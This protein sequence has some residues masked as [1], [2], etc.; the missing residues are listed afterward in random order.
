MKARLV[1]QVAYGA[2][3]DAFR[4][5]RPL[6]VARTLLTLAAGRN[7]NEARYIGLLDIT[8]E[9]VHSPI[10]E[11]NVLNPPSVIIHQAKNLC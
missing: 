2:R 9:F 11:L 10:D 7:M 8:V 4:S 3:D 5:T 6:A 1:A